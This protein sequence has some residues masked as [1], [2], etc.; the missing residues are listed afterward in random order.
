MLELENQVKAVAA[1]LAG[2][3]HVF[4]I[5][6]GRCVPIAYE[7]SLKFK[8]ITYIHSEAYPGGESSTAH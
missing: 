6:R 8:E 3:E 7:A 5:A 1:K 2:K 4:F